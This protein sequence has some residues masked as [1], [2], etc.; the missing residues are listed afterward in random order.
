MATKSLAMMMTL[1]VVFTVFVIGIECEDD[2]AVIDKCKG[3]CIP[4]CMGVLRQNAEK[5]NY[6]CEVYC[7][8]RKDVFFGHGPAAIVSRLKKDFGTP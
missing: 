3:Q 6:V 7:T 2:K 1:L 8:D 4:Y 5:S